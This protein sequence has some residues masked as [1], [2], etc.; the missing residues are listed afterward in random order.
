LPFVLDR[1]NRYKAPASLSSMLS[2]ALSAIGAYFFP[3]FRALYL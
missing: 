1:G 2:S 3:N